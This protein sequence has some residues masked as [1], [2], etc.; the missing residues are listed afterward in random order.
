V[1]EGKTIDPHLV[2][3]IVGRYVAHN[4]IAASDLPNLIAVV[5]RSLTELGQPGR[6]AASRYPPAL[7]PRHDLTREILGEAPFGA[8]AP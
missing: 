5:H 3:E 1:A 7:Q 8:V 4:S 2:A 6:N